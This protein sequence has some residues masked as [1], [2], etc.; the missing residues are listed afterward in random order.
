MTQQ[1][2]LY[3]IPM[4]QP[5]FVNNPI[6]TPSQQNEL[7]PIA[8]NL[9]ASQPQQNYNLP[10]LQPQL[11][12]D[13][14]VPSFVNNPNLSVQ[15]KQAMLNAQPQQVVADVSPQSMA[16]A[17]ANRHGVDWAGLLGTLGSY[18]SAAGSAYGTGANPSQG[19]LNAANAIQKHTQDIQQNLS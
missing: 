10:P 1:L 19:L 15:Q 14:T 2:P 13:N 9:I 4:P 3:Q 18:V 12:P 16:V 5:N 8:N 17:G 11:Q 6:L 7:Q